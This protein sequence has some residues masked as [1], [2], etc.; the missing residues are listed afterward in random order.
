MSNEAKT[1]NIK[2]FLA[3]NP[4]NELEYVAKKIHKKNVSF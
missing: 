1:E 2:L 4:Y 3:A